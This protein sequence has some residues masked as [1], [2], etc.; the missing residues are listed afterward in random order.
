MSTKALVDRIAPYAKGWSR[1]GTKSILNLIEQGQDELIDFDSDYM[2]YIGT[3]NEGFPPYLTT[4]ASTYKY[5]ITIANLTNI[6]SLVKN[7]G[8]TDRTIRCR[9]VIDVYIDVSSANDYNKRWMG[10]P[11]IHYYPNPYSVET[12]RINVASVPVDSYPALE[13]TAA[14]IIFK[15]DPGT[16][17]TTYFVKFAWEA[18]R[19]TS[20]QIPLAIPKHFEQALRDYVIGETQMLSNG[21]PNEFQMKFE[22]YWKPRFR[23]EMSSGA[24]SNNREV[25]PVYC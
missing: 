13:D 5:E 12:E 6:T 14:Y 2:I 10:R 4:T 9:Q 7:I 20:E 16:T 21:K 19:L 1:T 25:A 18:P 23:T 15:E 22:N 3:D 24:Q 11:A 8:G 17:T